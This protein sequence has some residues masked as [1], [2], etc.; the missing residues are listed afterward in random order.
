MILKIKGESTK[1]EFIGAMR[2][3]LDK[4]VSDNLSITETTMYL[5][6]IDEKNTPVNYYNENDSDLELEYHI[7]YRNEEEIQ[8]MLKQGIK[9]KDIASKLNISPSKVSKIKKSLKT[10][11]LL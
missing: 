9:Q 5:N 2:E 3:F 11:K 1:E 6:F 10:R 7:G 8:E 4:H